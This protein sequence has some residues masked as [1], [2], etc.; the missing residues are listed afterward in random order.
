[1]AKQ[2]PPAR[3]SRRLPES[4][5]A[6]EQRLLAA[7]QE[8]ILDHRLGPG[9]KLKELALANLFTVSRATVRAALARLGQARLVE[10][11]L[12]RGAVVASPSADESRQI[13]EARCAIECA[14]VAKLAAGAGRG[15]LKVLRD[16][17]ASE[18][19]SY[20]RGDERTGLRLSIGFHRQLAELAGNAVLARFLDELVA[21]TPLIALSHGGR[22][23]STCGV[24]DHLALIEAIA[25]RDVR[26]AV[27]LMREHIEHLKSQL[28]LHRPEPPR[29]LAAAFGLRVAAA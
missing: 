29:T 12:N 9:A 4:G 21:R 7:I 17:V 18:K 3:R 19:A 10:L 5:P 11:R 20:A 13:F 25:R 14:L 15:D 2:H 16:C 26:R 6:A 24:D 8:A 27:E 22:A 1:M 28:N 23:P